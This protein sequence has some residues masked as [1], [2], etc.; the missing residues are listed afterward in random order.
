MGRQLTVL[1]QVEVASPCHEE[2]DLMVGSD[3]V[4]FCERCAL[5]VYNLSAM[6][7]PEAELLV[8]QTEGRLCVRFFRRPDGTMLTENCPVGAQRERQRRGL[9][10]AG[11]ATAVAAVG[12]S[13]ARLVE[14]VTG[15]ERKPPKPPVHIMGAIA[16]R[17]D[18]Q[19]ARRHRDGPP[20]A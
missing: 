15:Q 18:M 10:V 1:D 7:Q 13:L 3:R 20:H 8:L 4:R 9:L 6:S 5:N 16:S 12:G 17:G 14:L 2:W 11:T 19:K